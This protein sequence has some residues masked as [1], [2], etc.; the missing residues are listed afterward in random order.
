MLSAPAGAETLAL[1]GGRVYASPDAAP[2]VDAVVVTTDGIITAIGSRNEVQVPPDARVIDC[3]GKTVVAGFWNSHVHFTQNV[4]KNASTAPAASLQDHMQEM[5]T[6]W[7]FTTVWDLGSDPRDTL[8]IRKRISAGEV[9][10]PSIFFAGN[11]FPKG[12]HPA[13]L[14]PEL[15]LPEA[16]TP[17]EATQ[18]TRVYL[19]MG[20]DGMKLFTGVYMGDKPVINMEVSIAKAAVD[21]AHAQGKPVFAHPQNKTGMETV[22]EAGVDVLAHIIPGQPGYSPEQL[23]KFK[24]QGIALIPTLSLFAKTI[25]GPA[26]AARLVDSGVQ[27]IKAFSGNGGAILFGTDVGFTTIYDTS[28]E[29]ELMRRALSEK[30]VL[31]TLTTNPARYF[32]AAKKGRVEKGFDADLVVLDG[33]PLADVSN[34]AK[35]AYTIRAGQVI[36]RK[37]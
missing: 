25:G 28:V 5:L 14:P 32:K 27:Q 19:G 24:A 10:G 29:Y 6:K 36:Y 4:W 3:T 22:I 8:P 31:A 33:D 12:G 35:V 18:M 34:L 13:Y 15:Q 7:G 17:E 9:L 1:A 37:P 30:E 16:A 23:A 20:L 11:I 26:L 2:L 21:V